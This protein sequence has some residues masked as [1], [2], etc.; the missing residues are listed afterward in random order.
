MRVSRRA[1]RFGMAL[2]IVLLASPS[3]VFPQSPPA[4]GTQPI[5][6][7][8]GLT[9]AQVLAHPD[10]TQVILSDGHTTT[11]GELR[12]RAEDRNRASATVR[13]GYFPL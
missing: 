8:P 4:G 9:L 2:V 3:G 1:L 5:R 13:S 6:V 10:A 7:T 12:R 11:V